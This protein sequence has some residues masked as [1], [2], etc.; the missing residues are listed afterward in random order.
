MLC[1]EDPTLC[2][3]KGLMKQLVFFLNLPLIDLDSLF[4][5]PENF[6]FMVKRLEEFFIH[7][8]TLFSVSIIEDQD[9]SQGKSA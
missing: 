2:R 8:R 5:I 1:L 4:G 3:K 9:G 7:P 6:L